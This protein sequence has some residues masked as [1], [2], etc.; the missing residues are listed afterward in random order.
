MP[1]LEGQGRSES[2]VLKKT[3]DYMKLQ[4]ED[5]EQLRRR[6]EELERA[7]G[8]GG[9][10]EAG[11]NMDGAGKMTTGIGADIGRGG[12]GTHYGVDFGNSLPGEDR[13]CPPSGGV[14]TF[15]GSSAG[16]NGSGPVKGD[17]RN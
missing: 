8:V 5:R 2:V 9:N 7:H 16:G 14:G 6:V 3:V 1:G 13:R 4:L 11:A 12:V 15:G 17:A 10:V